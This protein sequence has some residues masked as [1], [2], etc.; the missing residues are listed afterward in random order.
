MICWLVIVI[1]WLALAAIVAANIATGAAAIASAPGGKIKVGRNNTT[2][3]LVCNDSHVTVVGNSNTI[4][5]TG[6]C[7]SLIVSGSSN[8]VSIESADTISTSGVGNAITYQ[9]GTPR[10]T[11]AGVSNTVSRR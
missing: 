1:G 2:Q 7:A 10:V 5:A 8:Q 11:T 4:T 3:A 9:P 6:H